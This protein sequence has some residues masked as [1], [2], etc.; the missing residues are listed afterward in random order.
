MSHFSIQ[1]KEIIIQLLESHARD[2][3]VESNP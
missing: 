1:D 2:D 3:G